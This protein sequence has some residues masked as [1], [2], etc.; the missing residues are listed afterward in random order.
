MGF[1]YFKDYNSPNGTMSWDANNLMPVVPMYNPTNGSINAIFFASAMVQ[2]SIFPPDPNEWEPVPLPNELM[3]GNFCD[4]DCTFAHTEA[5]S[6]MHFY[7][8]DHGEPAF[9]GTTPCKIRCVYGVSI[10][11][12][13]RHLFSGGGAQ[14]HCVARDLVVPAGGDLL[15]ELDSSQP[16]RGQRGTSQLAS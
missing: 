14:V 2:Q 16:D 1:H 3:C 15:P 9:L 4:E 8:H 7:F 10:L 11:Q 12:G 6:T 13:E 5:W